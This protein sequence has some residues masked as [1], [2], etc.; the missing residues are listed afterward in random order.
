[1][2]V[3]KNRIFIVSCEGDYSVTKKIFVS[4]TSDSRDD[5]AAHIFLTFS[6]NFG[7]SIT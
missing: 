2:R 1:M 7:D 5:I 6:W 4:C 3:F